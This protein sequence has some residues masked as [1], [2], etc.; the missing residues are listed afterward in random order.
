MHNAHVFLYYRCLCLLAE[1]QRRP[2]AQFF[3]YTL[4]ELE[5]DP[6]SRLDH[7]KMEAW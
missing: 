5:R 6:N 7:K 4:A 2:L 3:Y 1:R